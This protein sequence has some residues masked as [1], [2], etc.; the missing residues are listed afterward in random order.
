MLTNKKLCGVL[1][2]DTHTNHFIVI[3]T[4]ILWAHPNLELWVSDWVCV[5]ANVFTRGAINHCKTLCK[6]HSFLC[7]ENLCESY[8][9]LLHRYRSKC[10]KY[11]I[12]P[13]YQQLNMCWE[14]WL[15]AVA[16]WPNVLRGVEVYRAQLLFVL[17]FVTQQQTYILPI[18]IHSERHRQICTYSLHPLRIYL[19]LMKISS[20]TL[21]CKYHLCREL[22]FSENGR[23]PAAGGERCKRRRNNNA[24]QQ[25][26]RDFTMLP[27][28]LR[29]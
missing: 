27:S 9:F 16:V 28:L 25:P 4:L 3:V 23:N 8:H 18:A 26:S 24:Q 5:G 29:E 10:C 14:A 12:H 22:R 17:F 1:V 11:P 6:S 20:Q 19:S 7:L 2:G 21:L 15:D 13:K